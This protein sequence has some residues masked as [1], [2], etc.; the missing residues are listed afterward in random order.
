MDVL[1]KQRQLIQALQNA[2]LY[3]HSVTDF[4]LIETHI[5]YVILTGEYAYKI[6]KSVN[7]GFLNFSELGQR[8]F[9][10]EEELRLNKRLAPS[11]YLEVVPIYGSFEQPSLENIGEPIEYMIK[12]QQFNQDALL[13]KKL[14]QI[15]QPDHIIEK[16]ATTLADFHQHAAIAEKEAAWGNPEQTMA[17][18]RENFEQ[19]KPFLKE[20]IAIDNLKKLETWTENQYK[21]LYPLLTARK[22]NQYIREGHGDLHLG[23]IALL[24]TGEVLIF[25]G[26]EFNDAFRWLDVMNDTAFL[27]M[28]LLHRQQ[29]KLAHLFISSYLE[30]TG[31]YQG[32]ALLNFYTVYR[33]LVRAKIALFSLEHD[34]SAW[35]RY[36]SYIQLAEN[37]VSKEVKPQLAITVAPSGAG[38]STLAKLLVMSY[39]FIR[40]RSDVERQRMFSEETRYTAEASQ[41]TYHKLL[42]LAESILAMPYPVI[43]DAT[44]IEGQY[45]QLFLQLA[46]KLNISAKLLKI[47]CS[48]EDLM[49]FI[50]IRQQNGDD[51][52]EADI[53]IMEKQLEKQ[54]PLSEEEIQYMLSIDCNFQ[55]LPDVIQQWL[56]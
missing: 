53:G 7:F 27:Y 1:E 48:K 52:S 56:V 32:L 44:F 9:Y 30:A 38:K 19:I 10:C 39:G 13:D 18:M 15:E 24:D 2:Q 31:D 55:T 5:S 4:Q 28:D 22:E 45:R 12:M 21:K 29:N 16:I 33:A 23:N 46:E 43:V 11:I 54:E 37:L 51:I 49:R 34:A 36:E 42:E 14:Q 35:Q 40:I 3:P 17:P 41:A 25:D 26:I 6:K 8:K 47:D 20:E 50:Q